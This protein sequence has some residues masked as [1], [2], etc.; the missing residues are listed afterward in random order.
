MFIFPF[1]FIGSVPILPSNL[2]NL[3]GTIALG[4]NPSISAAAPSP[5]GATIFVSGLADH[6]TMSAVN[7][8]AGNV[9][10][11]LTNVD[12]KNPFSFY[13]KNA[14]ALNAGQNITATW[15]TSPARSSIVAISISNLAD[16]PLDTSN[17]G[18]NSNDFATTP[19]SVI[20][21]G[22]LQIPNEIVLFLVSSGFRDATV[23]YSSGWN[24]VIASVHGN[25]GFMEIA[26]QIVNS[27]NSVSAQASFANGIPGADWGIDLVSFKGR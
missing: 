12:N 2:V 25:D 15:T 26:Y 19:S 14:L 21:T 10:L 9:Y 24:T 4:T 5:A 23:S 20:S 8:D 13:C 6:R 7:D 27:T 18:A 1:T 17:H 16:S 22:T 3:G 11:P